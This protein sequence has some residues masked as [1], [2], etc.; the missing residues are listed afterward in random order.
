M[1]I[2]I[3]TDYTIPVHQCL[4][5]LLRAILSN[6]KA[7]INLLFRKNLIIGQNHKVIYVST[8]VILP[9]V[10]ALLCIR[11]RMTQIVLCLV[12]SSTLASAF[13]HLKWF[14]TN[15]ALA[16]GHDKKYGAINFLATFSWTCLVT[17]SCNSNFHHSMPNTWQDLNILCNKIWQKVESRKSQN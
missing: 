7:K 14:I 11:H 9:F 16:P 5:L 4:N 1:P 8:D 13:N 10:K 6:I 15:L 3:K 17:H 12:V 2:L